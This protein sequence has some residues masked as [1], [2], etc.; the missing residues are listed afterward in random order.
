MANCLVVDAKI[1]L[2]VALDILESSDSDIIAAIAVTALAVGCIVLLVF[3]INAIKESILLFKRNI[4][5][6]AAK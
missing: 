3:D 2:Q 4:Q 5:S 6:I 1:V